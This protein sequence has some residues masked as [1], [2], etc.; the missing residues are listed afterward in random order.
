MRVVNYKTHWSYRGRSVKRQAVLSQFVFDILNLM[1]T[2]GVIPP[3][4]VLNSVLETGGS[5]GGMS[6]GTTWKPF[7]ITE[8]EYKELVKELL[9]VDLSSIRANHPYIYFNRII[10]DEEL[11][12]Y[13]DHISWLKESHS[14]YHGKM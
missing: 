4:V 9:E 14:K 5:S 10:V 13:T 11:N 12:Q 8:E 3:L 7:E 1:N 2:T 6:P